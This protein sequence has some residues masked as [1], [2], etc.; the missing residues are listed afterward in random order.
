MYEIPKIIS[1]RTTVLT[2]I[3]YIK[4]VEILKQKGERGR[5][6]R[7]TDYRTINLKPK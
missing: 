1:L 7:V 3:S 6:I 2:G 4:V 5:Q